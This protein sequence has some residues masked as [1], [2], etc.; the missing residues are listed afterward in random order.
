[1]HLAIVSSIIAFLLKRPFGLKVAAALGAVFTIVY[2]FL[3]GAQPSL[4][5]S[6]FMYVLGTFAI[7]FSLPHKAL[8]VLAL[9]F[10][11]QIVIEPQ[12]G[13]SISF[14][15]SYLSL[16]GILVVAEGITACTRGLLPDVIAEPLSVSLGAF[17]S[18]SSVTALFFGS[19]SF[20]GIVAGLVLVPLTTLFMVI[21]IIFL[22]AHFIIPP[23]TVPLDFI[24]LLIYDVLEY[25]ADFS[26]RVPAITITN[27]PLFVIISGL[28]PFVL[29]YLCDKGIKIRCKIDKFD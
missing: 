5:R 2:V 8:Q 27:I 17:I 12:S 23:L 10:L 15:L 22:A 24:L 14:I 21:S 4:T 16:A 25:I 19:I 9:S 3:V 7:L 28:V 20:V 11:L 18:T 6:A 1:M 13:L 26:G 29:L